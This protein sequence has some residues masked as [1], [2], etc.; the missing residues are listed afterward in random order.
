MNWEQVERN[1]VRRAVGKRLVETIT[2]F[3]LNQRALTITKDDSTKEELAFCSFLA[4]PTSAVWYISE[5][6]DASMAKDSVGSTSSMAEV[7]WIRLHQNEHLKPFVRRIM[8]FDILHPIQALRRMHRTARIM[9]ACVGTPNAS[10]F[11]AIVLNITYTI[12]VFRWLFDKS[13]GSNKTRNLTLTLMR[14]IGFQ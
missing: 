3:G 8:A 14:L 1:H 11:R 12:I 5:I 10:T 13:D 2:R 6:S 4:N 7:I 9:Y